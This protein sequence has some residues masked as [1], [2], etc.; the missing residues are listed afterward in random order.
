MRWHETKK[1]VE[2]VAN[3]I[4]NEAQRMR[5]VIPELQSEISQLKAVRDTLDVSREDRTRQVQRL[6]SELEKARNQREVSLS[7]CTMSSATN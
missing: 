6:E 5:K 2:G 4:Q 3:T 1:S 7:D